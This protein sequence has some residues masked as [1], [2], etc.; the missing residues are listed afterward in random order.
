[1]NDSQHLVDLMLWRCHLKDGFDPL[2]LTADFVFDDGFGTIGN[3]EFLLTKVMYGG[4]I[5]AKILVGWETSEHG[6]VVFW[7]ELMK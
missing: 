7:K 5:D 6:A 2:I 3:D 1:M 4:M